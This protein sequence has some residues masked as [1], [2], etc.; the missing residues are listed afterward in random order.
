MAFSKS[1]EFAH[2]LSGF[3]GKAWAFWGILSQL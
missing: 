1:R 2:D 3:K